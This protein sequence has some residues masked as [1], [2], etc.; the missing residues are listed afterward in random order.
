M[1][2]FYSDDPSLNPPEEYSFFYC[3]MVACRERKETKRGREWPI[4]TPLPT[5]GEE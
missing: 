5:N 2:V 4:K 1:F 3:V